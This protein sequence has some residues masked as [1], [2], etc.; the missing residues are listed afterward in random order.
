MRSLALVSCCPGSLLDIYISR[1]HQ[2][3]SEVK[4]FDPYFN[5][6]IANCCSITPAQGR[7]CQRGRHPPT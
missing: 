3:G 6:R 5:L 4:L 1:T 2:G 7:C